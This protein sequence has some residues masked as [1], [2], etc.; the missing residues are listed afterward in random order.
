M[1]AYLLVTL[2]VIAGAV[3]SHAV[4]GFGAYAQEFPE[5]LGY[6]SDYAGVIGEEA[7]KALEERLGRLQREYGVEIYVLTV[8]E[9]APWAISDYSD[10]IF[11]R[12][13][14]EKDNPERRVLLFLVA[15][16]EGLV[17][18]ATSRGLQ[19]VLPDEQLAK[20]LQETIL[21]AFH[22]RDFERG[23]TKGVARIEQHLASQRVQAPR[24][25]GERSGPGPTGTDILGI[26]LV[27]AG[28]ALIL[29]AGRLL[30]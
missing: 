19:G 11:E 22:A 1:R 2:A 13:G 25:S 12:W 17:R 6:V 3:L 4:S 14:L 24:A 5:R 16:E 8:K 9:T 30:S 20:V 18:L 28:L 26:L 10:R 27:V 21:P 15:V 23:I 29:L 7:Q